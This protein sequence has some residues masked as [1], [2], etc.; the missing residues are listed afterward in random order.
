MLVKY[1]FWTKGKYRMRSVIHVLPRWITNFF[2]SS[3]ELC[4]T[5]VRKSSIRVFTFVQGGWTSKI[6]TKTHVLKCLFFQFGGLEVLFWGISPQKPPLSCRRE[7][8]FVL[9]R[10]CFFGI[11]RNGKQLQIMQM[12]D[13]SRLHTQRRNW[14]GKREESPHLASYMQ[15]P[16]VP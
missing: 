10:I 2:L 11:V 15:K 16:A 8:N 5:V 6:L 13:F 3:M 7:W 9:V 1:C 14:W 4:R 12:C